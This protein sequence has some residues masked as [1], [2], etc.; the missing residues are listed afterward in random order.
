MRFFMLF[1]GSIAKNAKKA[2]DAKGPLIPKDTS[3]S[4]QLIAN[5]FHF[6]NDAL[7]PSAASPA[8]LSVGLHDPHLHLPHDQI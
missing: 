6:I 4:L 8:H 7:F 2:K 3:N 1:L 5:S